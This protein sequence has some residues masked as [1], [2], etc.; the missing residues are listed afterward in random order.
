MKRFI[1]CIIAVFLCLLQCSCS[2]NK[3]QHQIAA[4]TA[5]VYEFTAAI[6]KGTEISVGLVITDAVSCLHD[7]TLQTSQMRIL[8]NAENVI[9]SGV[10]FEDFLMDVQIQ[11]NV[12]DASANIP[13][14][15]TDTHHDH[16]G[17]SHHDQ[18]PHI[19]LSVSN[20]MQMANNIYEGLSASYPHYKEQ[21]S[22]NH[23]QLQKSLSELDQYA[24]HSLQQLS[25]RQLVTFHDGFA[26]MADGFDLEILHAIEE[27]SGSEAS[28]K[29]L[30]DI[31]K[32]I[33]SNNLPAIFT[34]KH[35]S[36]SAAQII[37]NETGVSVYTLNM[38]LSE[39][40]YFSA[41]Y[42]NI[43]TLKEALQ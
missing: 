33:D 18:D 11:G 20:A 19:W 37:S 16:D 23:D 35:G 41:M 15:C 31:C 5:P 42:H 29:E 25:T 9:I 14:L 27:E 26:Y 38:A 28:A 8:E 12:I 2:E 10:G 36:V 3:T 6:C 24:K 22:A 34:E 17:H 4:T 21:F 43:D 13:L 7:Y 30:S 39:S 32:L 40:G 1:I